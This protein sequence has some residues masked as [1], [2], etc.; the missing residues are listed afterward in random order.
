MALN[1]KSGEEVGTFERRVDLAMQRAEAEAKGQDTEKRY[2]KTWKIDEHTYRVHS[3]S[4][5]D[6]WY[7]VKV[8]SGPM[9][10]GCDAFR[11]RGICTHAAAVLRRIQS[12]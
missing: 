4:D 11:Y 8:G 3:R 7:T 5:E 6:V 2:L 12:K 1:L 9:R 10:C